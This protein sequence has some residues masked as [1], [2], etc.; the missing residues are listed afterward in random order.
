MILGRLLCNRHPLVK[1]LRVRR[2]QKQTSRSKLV[3]VGLYHASRALASDLV[4][5]RSP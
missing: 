3:Q 2:Q 5:K 1:L 4:A